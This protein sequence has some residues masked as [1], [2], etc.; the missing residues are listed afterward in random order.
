MND[1]I[2]LTNQKPEGHDCPH[3]H[4][5][6]FVFSPSSLGI[7]IKTR[8]SCQGPRRVRRWLVLMRNG[9]LVAEQE[10][11]ST[12]FNHVR[13]MTLLLFQTRRPSG[14]SIPPQG[15]INTIYRIIKKSMID[16]D[17]SLSYISKPVGNSRVGVGPGCK[18]TQPLRMLTHRNNT[19]RNFLHRLILACAAKIFDF[20]SSRA[21]SR[22]MTARKIVH[23]AS[24]REFIEQILR[25]AGYTLS[26]ETSRGD[27]LRGG[28]VFQTFVG[29]TNVYSIT[30]WFVSNAGFWLSAGET[31]DDL[32]RKIAVES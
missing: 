11:T 13:S 30:Y 9:I 3:V 26:P 31:L 1:S 19:D 27:I 17:I 20:Q 5:G 24:H 15:L 4:E 6:Y 21:R 25:P 16:Y 28:E 10:L 23:Y 29:M 12:L 8:V 14:L 32:M 2:C 7:F 22:I 18:L